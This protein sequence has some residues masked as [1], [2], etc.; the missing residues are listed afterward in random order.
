MTVGTVENSRERAGSGA[1]LK[2]FLSQQQVRFVERDVA[3]N[4]APL[5]ELQLLSLAIT[6]ARGPR[7]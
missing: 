7:T 4:G 5:D 2:E 1:L 6:W 3:R